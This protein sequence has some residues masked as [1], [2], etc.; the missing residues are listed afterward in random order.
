MG[1]AAWVTSRGVADGQGADPAGHRPGD[2]GGGGFVLGLADPPPVPRLGQPLA[3]PVVS[4]PPR[5][6]LPGLG[7]AVGHRLLAGFAVGQVHAVLGADRP[8]R[9][10]QP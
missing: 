9:H 6:F 1:A 7:C 5:A 10:Q 4:S 2:H 3:A 8:P